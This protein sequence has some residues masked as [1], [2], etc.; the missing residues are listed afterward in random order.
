MSPL[1]IAV[2]DDHELVRE[3][4]VALL[5]SSLIPPA[6]VTYSGA[7]L[8]ACIDSDPDIV[9]LDVDLGVASAPVA[10]NVT[11]IVNAFIPVLMISSHDNSDAIRSGLAAGAL[12]FIP[13]SVSLHT[14][15][16]ALKSVIDGDLYLSVDL[17]AILSDSAQTHN[18]EKPE[19]SPREL[20]ALRLYATG[21]TLN[22]VARKMNISP[23]TVKEYLDRVRTKYSQV[24]REARTRTELYV[25]AQDDGLLEHPH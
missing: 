24:G 23:H 15:N 13:K 12:G 1:R 20:D 25:A 21:L 6:E 5:T 8:S 2:V 7:E 9:L 19:L 14:L 16:Q 18:A 10:H 17:A 3:G 4:L 22:A 11:Q